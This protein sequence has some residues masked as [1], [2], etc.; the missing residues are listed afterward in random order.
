ME[1]YEKV[2]ASDAMFKFEIDEDSSY[3]ADRLFNQ[4]KEYQ[5]KVLDALEKVNPDGSVTDLNDIRNWYK[6]FLDDWFFNHFV[7]ADRRYD[8]EFYEPLFD[9]THGY[10]VLLNGDDRVR[11]HVAQENRFYLWHDKTLGE[12][13][14]ENPAPRNPYDEVDGNTPDDGVTITEREYLDNGISF[15][16]VKT[17]Y[18]Y[19][20]EIL[21]KPKEEEP[22][23][24]D[25]TG[26]EIVDINQNNHTI[27]HDKYETGEG[28][29]VIRLVLKL[30]KVQ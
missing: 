4:D 28:S 12:N 18:D 30:E 14:G 26:K 29:N 16:N 7:N 20:T 17:V 1:I 6:D 5:K 19:D 27:I 22:I 25:L 10:R 11:Y 3:L 9:E 21:H 13:N 2:H 15:G 8:L 24:T 23:I